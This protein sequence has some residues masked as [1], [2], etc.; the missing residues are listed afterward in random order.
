MRSRR[1]AFLPALVPAI[2]TAI[3]L[4][5]AFPLAVAAQPR[6][7]DPYDI[8]EASANA[9][10]GVQAARFTGTVDMRMA[11]GGTAMSM[12]MGMAGEY[13]APDSVRM[14]IDLGSLLGSFGDPSMSGP[15]EIVIV[16]DD[17]WMRMGSQPWESMTGSMGMGMSYSRMTSPADFNRHIGQMGRY[18]PNAVFAETGGVYQVQGDLDLNAAMADGM[19]MSAMMGMDMPASAMGPS[20]MQMFESMT[21][22]FSASINRSTL[23]MEGMQVTINIPDLRGSGDMAMTVDMTFSDYNSPSIQIQAPL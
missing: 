18:I 5:G 15:M 22:S 4:I 9:M 3:V 20:T 2:I 17:A 11:S 21:A 12:S 14:T 1:L 19:E 16:G 7:P 13:R 6:S 10:N 8:L 23:L